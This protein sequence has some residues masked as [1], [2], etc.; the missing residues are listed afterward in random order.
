MSKNYSSLFISFEG[1]EGSGK[2]VQIDLLMN[3][4][5]QKNIDAVT[6]REPGGVLL[7]EKIRELLLD[8]NYK[9]N[10]R[11]E[12]LLYEAARSEFTE[13]FLIPNLSAGKIVIANRFFDSTTAYQGYGGGIDLDFIK[14]LNIFASENIIPDL[15]FILDVSPEV[16]L[17]RAKSS[18]QEFSSGDWQESKN[19]EFHK[20]LRLGYL[21][22]AKSDYRF[23][24]IDSEKNNIDACH[25]EILRYIEPKLKET[26]LPKNH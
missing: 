22:M 1:G 2:D 19:I 18:K 3:Y 21:E 23:K 25:R 10:I 6:A 14:S 20:K 17:L 16:G 15:T 13:N 24:V 11:T 26:I 8:K 12:L 5:K 7:S 4:F 9:K